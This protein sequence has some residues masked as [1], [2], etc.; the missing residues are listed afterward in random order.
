MKSIKI[1]V[2][3]PVYNVENYLKQC[4][5]SVVNQTLEDIEIICIDDGSTDNSLNILEKYAV[6]DD[7][8]IIIANDHKGAGSARNTGLKIAKGN[9]ISFIDSDDWIE[10]D[11][12]DK[13]YSIMLANDP[14]MIFFKMLNYDDESDKFY[15]SD[16]YD[17]SCIKEFFTN[18]TYDYHDLKDQIFRIAVSPCNKLY[19]R[20]FLK[21]TNAKFPEGLIFEDNPFFFKNTL[22]AKKI[23][24]LDEY[25]YFRRRIKNSVM[26]SINEKHFDIIPITNQIE[27]V[28]KEY[29]LYEEFKKDLLNKKIINI[30]NLVYNQLDEKYKQDFF[31]LIK[32]DFSIIKKNRDLNKDYEKNLS[33]FNG[34]FFSNSEKTDNFKEFDLLNKNS[35]LEHKIMDIKRK[36]KE[37]NDLLQK[38]NKKISKK[39]SQ[40]SEKNKKLKEKNK[41]LMGKNQKLKEKNKKLKNELNEVYSSNSW[42]I[43][44]PFRKI[45]RNIK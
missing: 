13:L 29:N 38:K 17:L 34:H 33:P 45:M 37:K 18:L 15:S 43:S 24:L 5:N 42:K 36:N 14:D 7:R 31:K 16:Y 11:A 1:S 22:N 23:F 2:I 44:G 12:F 9:Y 39:N 25:L 21:Q 30:K 28:F 26:S 4:L 40:L 3:I 6:K 35:R 41:E 20:S 8:I 32:E 10:I 19:K 27:D